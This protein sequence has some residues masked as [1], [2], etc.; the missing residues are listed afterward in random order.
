MIDKFLGKILGRH[1]RIFLQKIMMYRR[2]HSHNHSHSH[3]SH[4]HSHSH[5]SMTSSYSNCGG[6]HFTSLE[7][8]TP[9]ESTPFCYY[10]LILRYTNPYCVNMNEHHLSMLNQ[11]ICIFSFSPTHS[12]NSGW[13]LRA[14]C[15]FRALR[16]DHRS[17]IITNVSFSGLSGLWWSN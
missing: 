10:L 7:N 12:F 8:K 13:I 16:N 4:S 5:S 6:E 14:I 9:C 1:A 11:W 2:H 15:G 17:G 3:H